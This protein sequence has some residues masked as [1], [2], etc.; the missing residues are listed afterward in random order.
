[1]TFSWN[2]ILLTF[3]FSHSAANL[4]PQRLELESNIDLPVLW[5]PKQSYIKGHQT[6]WQH[7]GKGSVLVK[8]VK[9]NGFQVLLNK[10]IDR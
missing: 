3:K 9:P 10:E 4:S 2:L 8:V 7:A 1:M 6:M 5:N